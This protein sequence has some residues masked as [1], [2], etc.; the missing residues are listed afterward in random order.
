M[1]QYRVR[2]GWFGKSILQQKVHYPSG[3]LS[4]LA[5]EKRWEDVDFKHA[6]AKLKEDLGK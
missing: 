5:D 4:P 1:T 6:P 3:I 2:K